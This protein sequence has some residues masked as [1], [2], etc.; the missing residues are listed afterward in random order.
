MLPRSF[1]DPIFGEDRWAGKDDEYLKG[2]VGAAGFEPATPSPPDTLFVCAQRSMDVHE[3][4][5]SLVN[6]QKCTHTNSQTGRG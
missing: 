4:N 5:L 3:H 1:P 2:L 6:R